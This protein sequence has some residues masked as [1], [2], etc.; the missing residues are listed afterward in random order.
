MKSWEQSLDEILATPCQSCVDNAKIAHAMLQDKPKMNSQ[1]IVAQL[2]TDYAC[3]LDSAWAAVFYL[4]TWGYARSLP[5]IPFHSGVEVELVRREWADVPSRDDLVVGDDSKLCDDCT[6]DRYCDEC[7][8]FARAAHCHDPLH[9]MDPDGRRRTAFQV[10]QAADIAR[11]DADPDCK[12]FVRPVED[13]ELVGD[14]LL[15]LDEHANEQVRPTRVAVAQST[16]RGLHARFA[17]REDDMPYDGWAPFY[18]GH[19]GSIWQFFDQIDD[20]LDQVE[21]RREQTIDE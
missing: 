5:R 14:A 12:W 17:V 3:T 6:A 21:Y 11:F 15:P 10:V 1:H 18:V 4:E 7:A 20:H 19:A 9:A 8:A 16:V 13:V 2:C